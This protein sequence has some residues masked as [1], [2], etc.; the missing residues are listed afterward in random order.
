MRGFRP[1]LHL[2][3]EKPHGLELSLNPLGTNTSYFEQGG[4]LFENE[5]KLSEDREWC[6][7]NNDKVR[8]DDDGEDKKDQIPGLVI[9]EN[10]E[11]ILRS[12]FFL[13]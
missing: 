3:V 9:E 8:W 2:S 12:R 1:K 13:G 4:R 7:S 10:G 6:S 11:W 5:L